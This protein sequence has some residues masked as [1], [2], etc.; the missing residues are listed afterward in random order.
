[1]SEI[2]LLLKQILKDT[3]GKYSHARVIS[4]IGFIALTVFMWKII[5]I[6][7][8]NIEFF[9]AY[10][11]YCTGTQTINKWLDTKSQKG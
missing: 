9:I 1:M 2:V 10:A 7:A 3:N 4:F 11:T 5:I 6:G 8:M